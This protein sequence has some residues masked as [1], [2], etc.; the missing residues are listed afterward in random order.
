MSE[1]FEAIYPDIMAEL[2]SALAAGLPVVRSTD[3]EE[4]TRPLTARTPR[5]AAQYFEARL[6]TG[7]PMSLA[8]SMTRQW[9]AGGGDAWTGTQRTLGRSVRTK[10]SD[11]AIR[12]SARNRY[13][14]DGHYRPTPM[15]RHAN[16]DRKV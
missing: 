3:I 14:W 11:E 13:R 10:R 4:A 6:A 2:E 8:I 16:M 7:M 1:Q 9:V 12:Q 15:A 5:T